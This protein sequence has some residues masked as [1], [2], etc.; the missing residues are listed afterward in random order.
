M[1]A[2]KETYQGNRSSA[3]SNIEAGAGPGKSRT[4]L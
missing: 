2:S 3:K 1:H 4:S